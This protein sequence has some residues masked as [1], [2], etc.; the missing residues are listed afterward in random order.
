M[1]RWN[2]RV[3][4]IN[5]LTKHSKRCSQ[6]VALITVTTEATLFGLAPSPTDYVHGVV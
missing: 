2:A 3:L 4:L 6:R 1:R 5:V